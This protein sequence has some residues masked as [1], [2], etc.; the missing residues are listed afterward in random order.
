MENIL[1][2]KRDIW[3]L[4]QF[5]GIKLSKDISRTL[6]LYIYLDYIIL[7]VYLEL[8]NQRSGRVCMS[9]G[10]PLMTKSAFHRTKMGFD[11]SRTSL[12]D[13]ALKMNVSMCSLTVP[14]SSSEVPLRRTSSS[15]R[16][17][18]PHCDV[19][20]PKARCSSATNLTRQHAFDNG[21]DSYHAQQP[22]NAFYIPNNNGLY[23]TPRKFQF[24]WIATICC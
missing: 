18:Q 2:S 21:Y 9:S 1:C 10:T 12:V 24:C 3:Y 22:R 15:S 23:I 19:I 17:E 6:K 11:G 5:R 16:L 14:L 7:I 8:C 20:I 4:S 13:T